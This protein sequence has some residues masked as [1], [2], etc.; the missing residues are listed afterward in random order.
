MLTFSFFL[1]AVLITIALLANCKVEY[2]SSQLAAKGLTLAIIYVFE[3]PP[4]HSDSDNISVNIES[5]YEHILCS[6][7]YFF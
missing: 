2:V 1:A 5:Q 6:R 7:N 3:F 4:K